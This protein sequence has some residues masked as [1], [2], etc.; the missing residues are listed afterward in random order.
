[1]RKHFCLSAVALAAAVCLAALPLTAAAANPV[2]QVNGGGT[3]LFID[4]SVTPTDQGLFTNFGVG[5]LIYADGSATGHFTCM[6]PGI[7]VIDGH[8]TAGSYDADTGV[9]TGSGVGIIY[10]PQ[11]DPIPVLFTNTFTAGGPG[12]GV[13]TLSETSGYFPV[14]PDDV[15]TE[16]VSKGN[17]TIR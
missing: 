9:A 2:A 13:F 14:Y 11:F 6:I 5:L 8:Y 7:V 1:M 3:G 12:V 15:D 4:P 16:V 10:F 17:I